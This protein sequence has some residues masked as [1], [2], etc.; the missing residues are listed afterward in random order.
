M[1]LTFNESLAI[2]VA[3]TTVGAVVFV[4]AEP[5]K[6]F[7]ANRDQQRQ[8]AIEQILEAIKK[9]QIDNGGSYLQDI[10]MLPT[11]A[12]ALIGMAATGCSTSCAPL[13]TQDACIDLTELVEQ[14]YLEQVPI[15]PAA[16]TREQTGYYLIR[17]ATGALEVG[18]CH[19]ELTSTIK[20]SK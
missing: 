10:A 18:A 6:R 4:I 13:L 15:D 3:A 8:V 11:D 7:K 17:T 1:K 14:D 2:L 5:I 20:V 9:D 16:G 12:P 19:P